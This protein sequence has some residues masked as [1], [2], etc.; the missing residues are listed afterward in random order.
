MTYTNWQEIKLGE[1]CE[2]ITSGSREWSK[3]YS[4]EG[5]LFVR[6]ENIKTNQLAPAEEIA[7]VNLP[8]KIEGTRTL[9][10]EGDLLITITGANVGKCAIVENLQETAYVSQSVALVRLTDKRLNSFIHKQLLSPSEGHAGKTKLQDLAYG[11]GRPVLS[12]KDIRNLQVSIPPLG[13]QHRIAEKLDTTLAAVEAC[14]QKLNNAA[15]TIQRFRQSVLAASVS[16]ALTREWREEKGISKDSWQNLKLRDIGEFGR[17]KSKHRPRNDPRLFGGDYPFIQT[18][19]VANSKGIIT[20]HKKTLSEFGLKQSKLWPS[21]TLCIT[22][23]A[24]I[25]DTAILSYPACFPD[26]VV[27]FIADQE[28]AN[29]KYVKWLI[30][31]IASDLERFAPATAQKN[32]NLA[33]LDE[34]ELA[35]PSPAE[36]AAAVTQGQKLLECATEVESRISKVL[37]QTTLM[38]K[39]LFS[40]A[41][42]GELVPQEPNDEPASALLERIKAQ[43]E[44]QAAA[45]KPA[46]RGRKKKPA[47]AQLVIPEGIV[48]NHLAKVL[49]ECGA[50]SERALLS[51]SE[52]EPAVFQ[53]QLTNEL[54]AGALKQVDIDGEAAYADAAWEEEG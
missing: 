11:I 43:R 5:S 17:G 21:G 9:I 8:G 26:S 3:Y 53:L 54:A 20:E 14:K 1:L 12:L 19:E 16:G 39:S 30:E 10:Q 29:T 24:N 40:K 45:K 50:L 35:I 25:A 18:G 2:L 49:E 31:S 7:R 42:R 36:Q 52:L 15:E 34:I 51:A 46:K 33:I 47:A 37:E 27:G 23:A 38:E 32:I 22:I 4:T 41:F 13:E 44:A 28:K 48:D 6:T